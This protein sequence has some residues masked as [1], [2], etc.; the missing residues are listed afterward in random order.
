MNLERDELSRLRV[1]YELGSRAARIGDVGLRHERCYWAVVSACWASA[2]LRTAKRKGRSAG[3]IGPRSE[4][5]AG[6]DVGCTQALGRAGE[7]VSAHCQIEI[8]N[9][10]SIFKSFYNLKTDLDSIQI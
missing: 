1:R 10:F 8:G 6:R 7:K 4:A 3:P 5:T 2:A 9:S